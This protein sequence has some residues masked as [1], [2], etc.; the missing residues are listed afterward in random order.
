MKK[1]YKML[2]QIQKYE[3]GSSDFIADLMK[4][5][6]RDDS[7]W[8]ELWMSAHEK[9]P[10]FLPEIE[11]N[12]NTA[13]SQ[14]PKEF[15]GAKDS[16]LFEQKLPYLFKILSAEKPLS[17]QAHP[18]L[19]QAKEGF[20][21]EN[22]L[23]I[24]LKSFKRNYKDDNHKPE[25][26]CALTEFH[27]MCGFRPADE[28]ISFFTKLKILPF[29]DNFTQFENDPSPE[30]WK[31]LFSE[32][33]TATVEKKQQIIEKTVKNF[34]LLTDDFVRGWITRLLRDHPNDIGVLSPLFLNTFILKPGQ[35]VFLEAGVLHAYLLGTGIEIMANSDNVLRGGLTS[36]NVDVKE[37]MS[38]L[39]WDMKKPD[40]QKNDSAQEVITYRVPINEFCLKRINLDGQL[41]LDNNKPTMILSIDGQAEVKCS[42]DS[43]SISQGQSLFVTS[44]AVDLTLLGE[45]LFFI[46]STNV[47]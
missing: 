22:E 14:N 31:L 43:Q 44:Q 4:V 27:A 36:K 15:L 7:P 9:A 40:I 23:G 24:E 19:K 3:W 6:K 34:H 39:K 20:A 45:G 12:L 47:R 8:A 10:S 32:I 5:E 30:K 1:M 33:L 11:Q 25:L 28:I 16:S 17:I 41:T 37:L 35:A 13:I 21:R 46:A 18:N 26:I 2:N 42:N 38:V 29:L